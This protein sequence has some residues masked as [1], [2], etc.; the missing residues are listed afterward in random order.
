MKSKTKT[1]T[2]HI[3]TGKPLRFAAD[4]ELPTEAV[5]PLS[6]A[7][8]RSLRSYRVALKNLL[9]ERYSQ[10]RDAMPLHMR[11]PCDTTILRCAD[12][13]IVRYDVPAA[14]QP[15]MRL[16]RLKEADSL[17]LLAPMLSDQV[18]YFPQN[19]ATFQPP[20]TG[21]RMTLAIVDA[22]GV[23]QRE[24][25]TVAPTLVAS[26]RW[27][28]GFPMPRPPSRPPCLVS[29]ANEFEL[30]LGGVIVDAS[31]PTPREIRANPT[32]FLAVARF[33][34]PVGWRAIEV[35]P[36]LGI[37]YWNPDFAS[38]WAEA[39]I[40]FNLVQRNSREMQLASLDGRAATRKEYARVLNEF[41][42]LLD[43]PEE[44]VHQFLKK[45]PRLLSP[46]YL[47]AWSKL[48]F[49]ERVSDFVM[50]EVPN[51]YVLIEIEAPYREVFRRDGQPRAE[52]THAVDQVND[53]LAYI[54]DN[55]ERVEKELGLAG[56]SA[57]PRAVVV[58][59]RSSAL[60]EEN[61]RKLLTMQE[62]QPRLQILT[63]DDVLSSARSLLESLLGPLNIETTENVRLFFFPR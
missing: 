4:M 27:P 54:R 61:R 30:S 48:P 44:P 45:Y 9:D 53:W 17:E 62:R 11:E 38:A 19:Q 23:V 5:D 47:R 32:N 10:A 7:I 51:D 50:R 21:P 57:S 49:G 36:P 26:S 8:G 2:M 18:L 33:Q 35:Y 56:I 22:N 29:T 55:R 13:M 40:L 15:F 20:G 34:L 28:E 14:D 31:E 41:T 42:A 12:G 60:S 52:L 46:S 59:G 16:G 3:E 6:D 1:G 25:A 39:D 43:G 58:I 37:E 24:A 63:Y